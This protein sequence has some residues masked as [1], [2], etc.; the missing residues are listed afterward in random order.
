[1]RSV[2]V[3]MWRFSDKN[4]KRPYL[5]KERLFFHFLLRIWNVHEIENILKKETSILA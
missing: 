4:F 5:K 3:A 2:L 1:M